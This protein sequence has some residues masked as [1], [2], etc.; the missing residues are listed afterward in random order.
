MHCIEGDHFEVIMRHYSGWTLCR[1]PKGATG[2]GTPSK[3]VEGWLPDNCLSD[4]P[5]NLAT[6]QQHLI[7]SGLQRLVTDLSVVEVTLRRIQTEGAAEDDSL[8]SLHAKVC[9]LAEEYRQ[10]VAVLQSNPQLL[11]QLEE[12]TESSGAAPEE[13]IPGLPSWVRVEKRCYYVSQTQKKLMRV[14]IKRVC[15]IRRQ[16]L[17]TFISDSNARKIVD[18]DA[19]DNMATCPLQPKGG[20]VKGRKRHAKNAT[21]SAQDELAQDLRCLMEAL[22]PSHNLLE[23]VSENS[24]NSDSESSYSEYTES[25]TSGGFDRHASARSGEQVSGSTS[26]GFGAAEGS[27]DGEDFRKLGTNGG[28]FT[29]E[30]SSSGCSQAENFRRLEESL[31]LVSVRVSTPGAMPHDIYRAR[32]QD[33]ALLVCSEDCHPYAVPEIHRLM[34]DGQQQVNVDQR[35]LLYAQQ[36]KEARKSD[37]LAQQMKNTFLPYLKE[38]LYLY[39]TSTRPRSSSSLV[40]TRGLVDKWRNAGYLSVEQLVPLLDLL[41]SK[42]PNLED[43]PQQDSQSSQQSTVAEAAKTTGLI[44]GLL[45]Q[46]Q[47]AGSTKRPLEEPKEP[48]PEPSR[49]R[50]LPGAKVPTAG[51]EVQTPSVQSTGSI[52]PEIW[53]VLGDCRCLFRAVVRS[54]LLDPCNEI[55]RSNRGEPLEQSHRVKEREAADE[56]RMM[57]CKYFRGRKDDVALLLEDPTMKVDDYI[58]R[59][60]DWRTWGDE[61]CLKFLPDV[62]KCPI[63]VYSWNSKQ[64][65]FFD[66]GMYIPKKK[67]SQKNDC[68]VLF[69][70]GKS[71]Y[72]L[73]STRW[74]MAREQALDNRR[75]K[76]ARQIQAAYRRFQRTVTFSGAHPKESPGDSR[77]SSKELS[78][79]PVAPLSPQR[80]SGAVCMVQGVLRGYLAKAYLEALRVEAIEMTEVAVAARRHAAA[81]TIVSVVKRFQVQTDM[82]AWTAVCRSV[83]VWQGAFRTAQARSSLHARR[84][85]VQEAQEASAVKIQTAQRAHSARRELARRK[86]KRDGLLLLSP[87]KHRAIRQMQRF[88]RRYLAW[89]TLNQAE[90][91][92]WASATHLQAHWRGHRCRQ[93]TAEEMQKWR[94]TRHQVRKT[95][96]L[97]L[98]VQLMQRDGHLGSLG[99]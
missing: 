8:Q 49:R 93:Q 86:A 25:T 89:C 13:A 19:F 5:R 14:I 52:F 22:G 57:L 64:R 24:E 55:E 1:R 30:T 38:W 23:D 85:Q 20:R 97:V 47:G 29:R 26:I 71:H 74:L 56:L 42:A 45:C 84:L 83:Q 10:I 61:I 4:H 41:D 36:A 90:A 67:A 16:I 88:G 63:Q 72:D 11:G 95:C 34:E 58:T 87:G 99:T 40:K 48:E 32:I 80:Q 12:Q 44:G 76:A 35:A 69:Y 75:E 27:G 91:M 54:R 98:E 60:E 70:N 94:Q 96:Q 9:G 43:R 37:P 2:E 66:A 18:F 17:V 81:V 50:V 28:Y 6:K 3:D 92:R 77:G 33:A 39:L 31:A 46:L 21:E 73:V 68:I 62:I 78:K 53:R 65:S 59:M 79:P 7:L 15:E 51:Q 82:L